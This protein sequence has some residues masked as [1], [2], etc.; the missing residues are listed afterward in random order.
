MAKRIKK[1]PC[2]FGQVL[3]Q[4]MEKRGLSPYDIGRRYDVSPVTI[5]RFIQCLR[6]P[7]PFKGDRAFSIVKLANLLSLSKEEKEKLYKALIET[8]YPELVK[9]FDEI[10]ESKLTDEYIKSLLDKKPAGKTW[11]EIHSVVPEPTVRKIRNIRADISMLNTRDVLKD[12]LDVLKISDKERAEIL[13]YFLK[14]KG[15]E[16]EFLKLLGK[17]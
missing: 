3:L 17:E 10:E 1:P 14:K 4:V 7:S 15:A 11:T 2:K 8:F 6:F 16:E 5:Q 12:Y 13:H 9:Y